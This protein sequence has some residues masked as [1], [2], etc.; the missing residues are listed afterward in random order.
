MNLQGR[1]L[2]KE[3]DLSAAEFLYLV[4][5]GGQLR[6]QKRMGLRNNRLAGRNIALIFEKTST[7]T[8]SAFEVAAHDEGAHVTYLGPEDSQLGRKESVK[9]TARVL[10]RMF[11]GIEYRGAAQETVETLGAWAGVPVWNGLTD[12]WHPTQMLAD[13]LTMR[14]HASKPLT[15]VS[16]CYLGDGRN[17]VANSLLVT[18]ALLG[19]DVRICAP[20]SLQP[21]ERVQEIAGK[22]AAESGALL[23][24][25]ADVLAAV[26]GADFL[27]TD[28]WLSMGESATAWDER[29]HLLMPYQVN[30]DVIAATG[31]PAVKFMHCLP[32]LHNRDTETAR[33]LYD[34]RRLTALE[35]TEEVFESPASI[36]FDQADNRM[37][38]IKAVMLATPGTCNEDRRRARGE[39]PARARAETAHLP[40]GTTAMGRARGSARRA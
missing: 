9:D 8:R 12:D 1:N 38:T 4:D 3:T 40:V 5:L 32:A 30:R 16:Y 17:N 37:H 24:V 11:D 26:A 13:I 15:E 28:V 18:G 31:N 33:R 27:Y 7:R 29:I 22:L 6:L 14:D 36:V 10:G 20:W 2:L 25:T 19:M 39:R 34:R 21:S 23:T 35:V